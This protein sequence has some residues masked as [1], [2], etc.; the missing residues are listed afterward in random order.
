MRLL[1]TGATGLLG[2]NLSL[3]AAAR[4][5]EVTGLSHSRQLAGMPF[6]LQ[7]V[8]LL[9]TDRSLSMIT[10]ARPEAIIHC[11]AVADINAAEVNPEM[12]TALNR[13]VPA[14]LAEAS[15]GWGIPLIY[16]SSDAVFD[17]QVGGYVESDLT[18]PL[19][20]YARTKL[21]GEQAVMAAN[22]QALI[23]RV[24]FFGWSLSGKRSLSEFFFNNL[25]NGIPIK[26]FTDTLF[27]PLYV[28]HLAD[29]LLGSLEG[30]L[31]GVYHLTSPQSM[32]KYEFGVRIAR[33]FGFDPN[34]IEPIQA[35]ET[36]RGVVRSLNLTLRSD[37]AQAAL[38]RP[39]PS[40][41]EGIE[42]FYQRWQEGYP[43]YL[44][45]LAV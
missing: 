20:L 8:D 22:P 29:L 41:D 6:N 2:L 25:K 40:V 21:A 14:R 39:L 43:E 27:C 38:W 1:V 12:T 15:S 34:L 45:S 9:D 31:S 23:A 32:S 36:D 30:D 18:N 16:I 44:Q 28:E 35:A 24:V 11:A 10:A 4:G 5:F 37:K 7:Q 33:R 26:G 17:G 3:R 13:D 19:S 42:A